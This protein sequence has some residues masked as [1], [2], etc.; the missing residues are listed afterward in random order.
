MSSAA[1]LKNMITKNPVTI[2]E[3][4]NLSKRLFRPMLV[5]CEVI[6]TNSTLRA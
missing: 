1:T 5:G 6:I 3:N 2:T 4:E